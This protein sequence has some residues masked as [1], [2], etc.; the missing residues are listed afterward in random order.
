M[1]IIES[2]GNTG[3]ATAPASTPAYTLQ[4][5]ISGKSAQ[6][7]T[8]TKSAP[9]QARTPL[10]G[11]TFG[12]D[13]E[14]FV[15]SAEGDVVS[16]HNLLPGTK[17][18]PYKVPKGAIQVD[19]VLA[20]FNIDP[21]KTFEEFDDAIDTVLG[22]LQGFLPKGFT[23]VDMPSAQ[24]R[25]PVW[26]SIPSEAKVLGCS[27]D[28]NAWTGDVNLPPDAAKA[29][30]ERIRCAGGHLHLGW[31][32]GQ[33]GS[34]L[35]HI[36]NCRDLVRQFDWYLGGWSL[37]QDHDSTRRRLYGKAG[38]CRMKPYG[39]E[40]R[41]LSNFWVLNKA[42]RLA[43]WN[44]MCAAIKDMRNTFMPTIGEKSNNGMNLDANKLLIDS[45]NSSQR[46]SDLE[47]FFAFPVRELLR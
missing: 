33:D 30:A 25:E 15:M 43:V 47:R 14:L 42:R 31:T 7:R 32:D 12:C 1:P 40:Y 23:L 20:E 26:N 18:A 21:V 38:S 36:L 41:V 10:P 28:M 27:P 2:T 19:G 44:R 29:D 6:M 35:Q 9:D 34:D 16:A 37:S 22:H 4:P 45:I 13:P 46:S 8:R 24:F 5:L 39:V 17:E 11:F 3:W